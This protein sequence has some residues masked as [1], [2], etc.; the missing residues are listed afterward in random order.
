MRLQLVQKLEK[1]FHDSIEIIK[2]LSDA[3]EISSL[4]DIDLII[5]TLPL[6]GEQTPSVFVHPY[7]IEKDYE[8]IQ[9]QV[10]KL[11]EQKRI[12]RLN[13]IL[14]YTLMKICL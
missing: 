12:K 9:L 6:K 10:N 1:R 14:I 7:L 2:V 8:Y 11:N 5:S 3:S 4:K 13:N